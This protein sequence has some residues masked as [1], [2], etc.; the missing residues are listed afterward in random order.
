MSTIIGILLALFLG[1]LSFGVLSARTSDGDADA[2]AIQAEA[3][4]ETVAA[5]SFV[6]VER[7]ADITN[8]DLGD[9]GPS[10][11]DMIIWGPNAL[12][13]ETNTTDTGATT[14]GF[15]VYL[16]ATSQCVLTETILL[17]D[18]GMLQ[19]QGI[20]AAGAGTSTRFIVGGSGQY[21]G[22]TGTVE[23]EPSDDL[24]TWI[25]TFE[26]TQETAT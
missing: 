5:A 24:N 3:T 11:G 9:P 4:V 7:A 21:L 14:Q 20:Q 22:A 8:L 17:D 2:T 12:Y 6:L 26:I 16:D 15:C 13:D 10:A 23:I 18:G 1:V 19:L 25:K